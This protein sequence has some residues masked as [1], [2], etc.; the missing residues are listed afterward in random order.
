M[1][2]ATV[3]T[4]NMPI[5][6]PRIPPRPKEPSDAAGTELERMEVSIRP[7][8]GPFVTAVVQ[9][10]VQN[11]TVREFSRS[12]LHAGDTV[13]SASGTLAVSNR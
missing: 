5:P 8:A 12:L 9:I 10:E 1:A 6:L 4:P 11:A 7:T 2:P 13:R 3:P